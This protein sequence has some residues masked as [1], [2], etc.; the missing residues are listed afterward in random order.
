MSNLDALV[1][2]FQNKDHNAFKELY[3]L[4]N[5]SIYGIIFNIVKDS[6]IAEELMQDTFMKAW[7]K[8][9]SYSAKKGRFFTWL[10]NI[11]RNSALDKI[12]SKDYKNN[13]MNLNAEDYSHCIECS[14]NLD[15]L[16]NTIGLKDFMSGLS[17]NDLKVIDLIYF[18]G[19]T[20]KQASEYLKIPIG[21][22]KTRNRNS[23]RQL[24]VMLL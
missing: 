20:H 19:Y 4:Y 9:A 21:T 13:L 12:R 24:R 16:T 2:D 17:A 11:A 18:K 1:C 22:V 6:S 8:S 10:L 23:I 3:D 15:S 5:S 14:K 7:R